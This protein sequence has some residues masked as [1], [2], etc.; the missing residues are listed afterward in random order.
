MKTKPKRKAKYKE[1]FYEKD[2]WTLLS[3]L[4]DKTK[5]ILLT[6]ENFNLN[7]FVHGSVARGNVTKISDIDIVIPE[8]IPSFQVE[9]TLKRTKLDIKN[10][11]MIQATPKHSMKAYI[12]IDSMTTISFPLMKLRKVEREFYS[13][14]GKVN[15]TSLI[16]GIRVCGVDKN[17]M[18]IEP[19]KTGH[20]EQSIIGLENYVSKMLGISTQTVLDRVNT[21]K[22]RKKSGRTGVFIKKQISSTQTFEMALLK[23]VNKNPAV[24]RRM[25]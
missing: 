18:M 14:G 25:N 8:K 17:L 16:S 3:N 13:F 15:L 5:K 9:S 22:K 6:F 10:K 24:K 19:T 21:L 20:I 2:Q 7:A 4:R 11:Y 23:I 1:V 12:E